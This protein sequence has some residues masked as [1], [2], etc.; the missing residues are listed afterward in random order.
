[1]KYTDHKQEDTHSPVQSV[2]KRSIGLRF[3]RMRLRSIRTV[4]VVLTFSNKFARF[5]TMENHISRKVPYATRLKDI[6]LGGTDRCRHSVT[7]D[8]G[9]QVHPSVT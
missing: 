5:S 2:D 4:V 9:A 3:V 6:T 8:Q 7:D 1:M